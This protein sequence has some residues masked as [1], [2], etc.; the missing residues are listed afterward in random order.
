MEIALAVTA[1][2]V[3]VAVL[4]VLLVDARRQL[5]KQREIHESDVVRRTAA[6]MIEAMGQDIQARVERGVA[7]LT[8]HQEQLAESY[9][10]QIA[11]AETRARVAEAR[12]ADTVTALQAATI[13]VR[14]LRETLDARAIPGLPAPASPAEAPAEDAGARQTIL[15]RAP[16]PTSAVQP[17]P[18]PVQQVR[19][20]DRAENRATVAE[21]GGAR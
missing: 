1:A 11:M 21:P 14:E 13:L 7:A 3:V 8:Q 10:T 5:Q 16:A 19:A 2:V 15:S 9:R 4:V 6:A 12:A 20:L 18:F 17:V